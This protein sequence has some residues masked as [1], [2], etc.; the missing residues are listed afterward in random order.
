M[1]YISGLSQSCFTCT[2]N[3]FN[4]SVPKLLLVADCQTV[5]LA[6]TKEFTPILCY[7]H[8]WDFKYMH[9]ARKYYLHMHRNIGAWRFNTI[10]D[11]HESPFRLSLLLQWKYTEVFCGNKN[12]WNIS[13]KEY[14]WPSSTVGKMYHHCAI[15]NIVRKTGKAWPLEQLHLRIERKIT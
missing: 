10:S 13:R 7:Y 8:Q 4:V 12:C 3:V 2:S 9:L 1:V 14:I 5:N 11:I 6:S 15:H